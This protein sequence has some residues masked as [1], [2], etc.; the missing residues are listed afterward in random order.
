MVA[1]AAMPAIEAGMNS[2]PLNQTVQSVM[3]GWFMT[4]RILFIA[5]IT[6][7]AAIFFTIV[8]VLFF[9]KSGYGLQ[10]HY[11]N[12]HWVY[13]KPDEVIITSH[14][15]GIDRPANYMKLNPLM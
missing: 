3:G 8:Y 14:T 11:V 5:G 2:A 10:R 4:V 1:M 9:R 6:M 13:D 15:D 7:A 12:G